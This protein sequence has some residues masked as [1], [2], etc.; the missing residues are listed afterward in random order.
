[1]NSNYFS[2]DI[3]FI[4]LEAVDLVINHD[5]CIKLSA[6]QQATTGHIQEPHNLYKQSEEVM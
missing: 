2:L 6:W 1:M 4:S 3:P 5:N